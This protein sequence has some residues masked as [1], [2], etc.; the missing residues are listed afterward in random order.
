MLKILE[1]FYDKYCTIGTV[2]VSILIFWYMWKYFLIFYSF[3]SVVNFIALI[4]FSI[5]ASLNMGCLICDIKYFKL[6]KSS[7]FSILASL[8]GFLSVQGCVV[9][10]CNPGIIFSFIIMIAPFLFHS[11]PVIAEILLYSS[12]G[13][14]I[15]TLFTSKCFEKRYEFKLNKNFNIKNN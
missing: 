13:I 10:F 4:S 15:L 12:I 5:L 1:I 2:I 3:S 8:L 7:I 11:I 14:L 6:N 9:L